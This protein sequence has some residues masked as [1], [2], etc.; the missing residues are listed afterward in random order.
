MDSDHPRRGRPGDCGLHGQ[1]P[2]ATYA[3]G[4]KGRSRGG[5]GGRTESVS[6]PS[7]AL[8]FQ[9][10]SRLYNVCARSFLGVYL[11][12]TIAAERRYAEESTLWLVG[13]YLGWVEIFRR[14]VQFL[15]LGSVERN[16]RLE[17][18]LSSIRLT[19]L[20]DELPGKAFRIFAADQRAIGEL[21]ISWRGEGESARGDCMGYAQFT[22]CLGDPEFARWFDQLRRELHAIVGVS[23][24]ER[25]VL[26]QRS[27]VDLI[28]FLDAPQTRF[29]SNM[30]ERLPL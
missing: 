10:Q 19:L 2:V 17:E 30:L 3:G 24:P 27:L 26:L 5:F 20:T 14:E 1:R 28:E 9:L 13:Q 16:R 29:P 18:L 12:S 25:A 22:R 6:R 21:M 7:V 15:D 4:T 8:A 11:R 23:C